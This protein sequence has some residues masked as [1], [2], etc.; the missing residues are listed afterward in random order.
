MPYV[1]VSLKV[2]VGIPRNSAVQVSLA[3]ERVKALLAGVYPHAIDLT[4]PIRNACDKCGGVCAP[5]ASG[6][7]D[8][9]QDCGAEWA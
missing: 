6:L 7:I 4:L 3:R 1:E 5:D 2:W 8:K 9:C